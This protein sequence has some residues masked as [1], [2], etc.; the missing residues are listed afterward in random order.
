MLQ[1]CGMNPIPITRRPATHSLKESLTDASLR[2][3]QEWLNDKA[4]PQIDD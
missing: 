3:F 2:A 1:E 4:D